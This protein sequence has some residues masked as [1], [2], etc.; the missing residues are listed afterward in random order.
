MSSSKDSWCS[1]LQ[2][3]GARS[4]QCKHSLEKNNHAKSRKPTYPPGGFPEKLRKVTQSYAKLKTVTQSYAKLRKYKSCL[5]PLIITT[6]KSRKVTQSY[7][8]P[9]YRP[10]R[11][12]SNK[13][14]PIADSF[15]KGRSREVPVLLRGPPTILQILM[16]YTSESFIHHRRRRYPSSRHAVEIGHATARSANGHV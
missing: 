6:K 3:Y 4:P 2:D 14:P 13:T 12:L 1:K 11:I 7:V 15:N 5:K 10:D 8:V 16:K 9:R